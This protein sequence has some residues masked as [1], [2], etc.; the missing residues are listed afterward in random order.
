LRVLRLAKGVAHP[1]LT[2]RL[3]EPIFF[4]RGVGPAELHALA[5][6][7]VRRRV[8]AAEQAREGLLVRLAAANAVTKSDP[9]RRFDE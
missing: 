5:E 9:T 3:L 6:Q 8:A 4:S 1:E 7:L 2:A